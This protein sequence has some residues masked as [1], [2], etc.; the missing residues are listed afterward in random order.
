MCCLTGATGD[1]RYS[2]R[3]R[4]SFRWF[5]WRFRDR[6]HLNE[7]SL[8]YRIYWHLATRTWPQNWKLYDRLDDIPG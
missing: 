6:D 4:L 5:Q 2:R 7:Y 1:E 3:Q 8:A